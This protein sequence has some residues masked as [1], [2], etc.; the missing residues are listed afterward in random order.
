MRPS[1]DS[2]IEAEVWLPAEWNGKF[3]A[4]GN[5]GWAGSISYPAMARALQEGYA[6]ASTD[7]GH[8][9]GNASFAIGHPEK[10]IDFGYRA[11]H[12]MTVTGEGD[13]CGPLQ[14]AGAAVVLER[15]FDRRPAGVDGGA[16]LSRRLRRDSGRCAREQSQPPRRVATGRLC[17]DR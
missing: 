11:V 10:L 6:T 9:G 7:T 15:V 12:E 5:G 16:A 4:V 1:G 3:Q 2:H 14:T 17:A 8:K 13:H